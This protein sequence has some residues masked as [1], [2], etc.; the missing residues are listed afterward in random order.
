MEH[1]DD[2][3]DFFDYLI[4]DDDGWKGIREDAPEKAKLAYQKYMNQQKD[5][6]SKGIKA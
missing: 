4:I 5:L 3:K 1:F 2:V 6:D